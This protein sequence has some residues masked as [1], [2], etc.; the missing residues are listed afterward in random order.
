MNE[1]RID[2]AN[3]FVEESASNTN[4]EAKNQ[5]A[6]TNSNADAMVEEKDVSDEKVVAEKPVETKPT[7]KQNP[8]QFSHEEQMTY[9]FKKQLFRQNKKHA[10]EMEEMRKLVDDLKDRLYNPDK[11]KQKYRDDFNTADEYI[12]YRSKQQ[13]E[14]LMAQQKA[15]AEAEA[16]KKSEEDAMFSYYKERATKNMNTLFTTDEAR[17]EYQNAFNQARD[18]GLLEQIDEDER[19]ASYIMRRPYGPAILMELANNQESRSRLFDDPYMTPDER[20]DELRDIEREVKQKFEQ[21]KS[22][23]KVEQVKPVQTPQVVGK[24]GVNT[25][26]KKNIWDDDK[27]LEAFLDARR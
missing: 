3:E 2:E 25:I 19:V 10:A 24:P 17:A 7:I 22:V 23:P 15:Q 9:S 18:T 20:M 21:I 4:E 12:D 13:F 8:S 14:S 27:S 6:E 11:Y 16:K 1:E 26:S 5:P